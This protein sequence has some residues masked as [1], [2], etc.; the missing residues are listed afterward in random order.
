MISRG[1]VGCDSKGEGVAGKQ[2]M[3]DGGVSWEYSP[4]RFSSS[5]ELGCS[6]IRCRDVRG[7]TVFSIQVNPTGLHLVRVGSA[8]RFA[9]GYVCGLCNNWGY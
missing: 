7:G 9:H 2:E 4:Q 8:R 5:V 6:W 1:V 3:D